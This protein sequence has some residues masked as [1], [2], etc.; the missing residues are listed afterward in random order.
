MAQYD[1]PL[2]DMRFVFHELLQAEREFAE[3]GVHE[4]LTREVIDHVLGEAAKFTREVLQ[5]INAQGDQVGCRLERGVVTTPPG[6]KDAYRAYCEAGW[7]SVAADPAFG[8]Q[9]LPH[10]IGYAVEEMLYAANLAWAMYPTLTHGAYGAIRVHG[11]PQQQQLYLPKMITGQ[12]TGTMCLTEPQAGTDLGLLKTRAEPDGQGGYTVTGTKIF[13][14]AGEHDLSE[15]IVHLVLARLPEAPAGTKGISLFIVPKFVPD[16][17][18]NVGERNQLQCVSL[19]H[20]MGIH[21][22]A[23]CVLAF[24][25]AKAILLGE[26]HRGLPA[27]FVMMNGARLGVGIQGLGLTEAAYQKAAAY[28][29]ERLQSRSLSGAKETLKPADPI[30]VHADV[31]RMLLTQR[32]YAEGGRAFA[33]WLALQLDKSL[34]HP[35]PAVREESDDLLGLFTPVLKAFLTDNGFL[36]TNLAL[37]VHGGHGYITET[38]VEQLVRDS[39]IAMIYEGTNGVQALDLLG[40]KVLLDS[41][42]K[43]RRFGSIVKHFVEDAGQNPDMGEFVKPLAALAGRIQELTTGLGMRALSNR[44]E[45]GAAAV[46][47]LRAMGHLVFAYLWARM[48]KLALEQGPAP[49]SFYAAKLATARVYYQRL[50]P[51]VESCLQSASS[52]AAN[53]FALEADAFDR[54]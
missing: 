2:R 53:L 14:S 46:D 25:N 31:R 34:N 27:M 24:D 3:L 6:F 5:P 35:D 28:A 36:C 49:G 37:Q 40:R 39:R 19:E 22:N 52:G 51:E 1:A 12:W 32:A 16:A 44:D 20:K 41:G 4:G 48:A 17:D 9:G 29:K 30:I 11:T 54:N 26:P 47:Y 45:V 7:A 10:S 18:G 42:K 21:G 38:G 13:V 33:F 43:L 23:T 15:N 8:G 50:L